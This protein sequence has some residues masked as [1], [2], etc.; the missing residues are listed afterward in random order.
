MY[1]RITQKKE[2]PQILTTGLEQGHVHTH[3]DDVISNDASNVQIVAGYFDC[4]TESLTDGVPTHVMLQT[5]R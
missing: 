1:R 2:T 5:Q 4:C 3:F